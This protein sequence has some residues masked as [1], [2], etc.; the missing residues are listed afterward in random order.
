MQLQSD[1][2]WAVAMIDFGAPRLYFLSFS[3]KVL[4]AANTSKYNN[5][6]YEYIILP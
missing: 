2:Q 3:S 1:D 6:V 5:F 4:S